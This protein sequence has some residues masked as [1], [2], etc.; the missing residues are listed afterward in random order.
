MDG[1]SLWKRHVDK[2]FEGV[3]ECMVCFSVVHGTNYQLP[4][5]SCRV[6]KKKF[7]S[8]CLVRKLYFFE[9]LNGP[10]GFAVTLGCFSRKT[11]PQPELP[12]L[13][14]ASELFSL[15]YEFQVCAHIQ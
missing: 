6:C 2:K 4:T 11:Q 1:L 5:I 8:A 13:G 15:P 10:V 14:I 9:S 12:D 7:H 3:E